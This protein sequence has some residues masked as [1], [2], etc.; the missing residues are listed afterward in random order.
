MDQDSKRIDEEYQAI[1]EA[2]KRVQSLAKNAEIVKEY[3]VDITEL[4]ANVAAEREKVNKLHEKQAEDFFLLSD[5]RMIDVLRMRYVE[6]R[7]WADIADAINYSE[8]RV[9][10]L[11][12]MALKEI[13]QKRKNN[14]L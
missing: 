4:L 10:E 13:F 1:L 7:P 9:K 6:D 3:G 12:N 8:R 14:A 2:E 11:R 5:S